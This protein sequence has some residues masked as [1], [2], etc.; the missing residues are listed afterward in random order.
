MRK[1]NY[2]AISAIILGSLFWG[3]NELEISHASQT[4]QQASGWKQD[5]KGW[6]YANANGT[7]PFALGFP[8]RLL[9]CF[10]PAAC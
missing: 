3:G 8:P 9:S 4:A 2:L 5:N 6:W 10:Q 1:R 7:G